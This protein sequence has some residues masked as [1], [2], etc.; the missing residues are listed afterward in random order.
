VKH[1]LLSAAAAIAAVTAAAVTAV[2][3]TSASASTTPATA[4][5][6]P[7]RPAAA[8]T[9]RP[10]Y[11]V[12]NESSSLKVFN[13]ATGAAVGALKAPAGL[14]FDGVA[15]G[16]TSRTFLAFAD[17]VS[18]TA[19]CHAYYYSFQ[20]AATGKP[21]GLT[22]LRSIAGSAASAIAASPGGGGYT[23]SAVHCDTAPPNG[24]IGIS[25]KAGNHTWAY[26]EGDDYTFSL[27]ATADA[28][29]LALSLFAGSGWSNLLLNTHSSAA[30]V[31]G[32]S[33]ILPA[34]PYAQTLAISPGGTTLYACIS[35]GQKGELAAYSAA[36][37]KLIRVLHRWTLAPA[38]FYFCQVSADE[39]GRVL[40]ATYSSNLARHTALIAVN[41]QAGTA[42]ALPVKA[43][44]V[45]DGVEAAW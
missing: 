31:D 33:R 45:H 9:F 37:G 38:S 7:A 29:T 1:R 11:V 26:D 34:V 15:S 39:T 30:T 10:S 25:G 32:A 17:P 8:A 18:I 21:S 19:A 3:L 43:D 4:G 2:S 16:G 14:Q 27:A 40:L 35:S 13:A 28:H 6:G 20:L 5:A 36:T 42:V 44:Y 23:Y 12:V 41:P 22:P 24:L